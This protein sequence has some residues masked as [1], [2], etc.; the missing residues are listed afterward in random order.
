MIILLDL[1]IRGVL[2]RFGALWPLL[3]VLL[4]VAGPH[5]TAAEAGSRLRLV[6]SGDV[7]GEAEPCAC[8]DRPLGG[9]AQRAFLVSEAR[10]GDAPTLVLDAGNLLFRS[11]MALSEDGESCRRV[12][13][14]TLVD[15][16]SMMA[17]DAVNVGPHDLSTGLAYLQRLQGRAAFPFISSNLVNPD[18][19]APVFTQRL[20]VD[21]DGTSVAVI[22]VLPGGMQG[23]GY[24]TTDPIAVAREQAREARE[25]G[26][27]LVI[28]LSSLGLDDERK[29]ARKVK[30]VDLILG[31]GD[32]A[33][34]E[35]PVWI[36]ATLLT[37]PASRGKDMTL[38]DWHGGKGK[39]RFTSAV[40]LVE[41]GGPVDEDVHELVEELQLRQQDPRWEEAAPREE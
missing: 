10:G 4:L 36:G 23:A 2:L 35:P 15:A 16:Y 8:A 33:R 27:D 37:H 21:R 18:S 38:I 30:D 25:D 17:V 34:T 14:L 7:L 40:V 22:G 20:T 29:L 13:A 28:L 12:S 39:D 31:C 26:A 5:A 3:A 9:L 32:R 24:R 1:S 41:R 11:L 6:H 19:G